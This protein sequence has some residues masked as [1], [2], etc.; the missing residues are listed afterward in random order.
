MGSA[1]IVSSAPSFWCAQHGLSLGGERSRKIASPL[2]A[3]QGE[4]LA[5][6]KGVRREAGSEGSRKQSAGPR[7]GTEYEAAVRDE[8]AKKT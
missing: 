4:R 3:R 6:G 1:D 2:P 7:T 8:G 5:K